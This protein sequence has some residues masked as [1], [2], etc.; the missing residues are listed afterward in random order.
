MSS[1]ITLTPAPQQ[2]DPGQ[3][4]GKRLAHAIAWTAA[5]KW[6][7]QL[8]SWA[9]LIVV[10]RL[11]SPA[12]FGVF[13]IADATVGLVSMVSEF[14]LGTAIVTIRN[15]KHEQ[16]GQLH[17][18]SVLL[19]IALMGLTVVWAQLAA[20]FLKM[21]AV[22]DVV[23]VLSLN[24]LISSFRTVPGALLQK[25]LRFREISIIEA[26]Q[27]MV[28]AISIVVFAYLGFKYWSFV[29]GGILGA[30]VGAGAILLRLP[31][32]FRIP[33][34]GSLRDIFTFSW[35]IVVGR[36]SWYLYSN[37]DFAVAGRML[38]AGPLG[39]YT[40]AWNLATLPSEK[41]TS[42]VLRVTPTFFGALNN[43]RETLCSQFL[44]LTEVL[45]TMLFPAVVGIALIAND[46]VGVAL[47]PQWQAAAVPLRLL[48]VCGVFRSV[49]TLLPQVLN[50]LNQTK[51]TMW[52][53]FGTLVL[54]PP[55]F[56]LGSFW[57]VAGIASVWA[58]V[59][60]L[61]TIPFFW[62][63][64]RALRLS[65]SRYLAAIRPALAGCILIVTTTLA[66]RFTFPLL[67]N[68]I[69][70]LLEVVAGAVGYCA[71]FATVFSWRTKGYV[72]LVR[73]LR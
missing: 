14:G 29:M 70:L 69:R 49:V 23:A 3:A 4:S 67:S 59:Y 20:H 25:Q 72:A 57:G 40:S 43:N 16:E 1:S 61:T 64:F 58:L 37:A 42:L 50:A 73:G 18:A 5:A 52:I 54:L 60:P 35:R 33:E 53:S 31:V 38:G 12:D 56:Y 24:F 8:F 17:S 10:L 7:S 34:F 45:A 21:E 15:L 48:A 46:L 47:G 63:T 41:V 11:V 30:T 66:I 22:R 32:R 6:T 51:V 65:P 71:L 9:A 27:S 13:G 28:Q 2:L 62:Y 39:I 55:S 68:N 26:M 36:V 19:G 44:R